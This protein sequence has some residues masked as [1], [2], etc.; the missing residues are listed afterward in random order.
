MSRQFM[1]S[2]R[3]FAAV[4]LAMVATISPVAAQGGAVAAQRGARP[5][6]A[7]QPPR[8]AKAAARVDLTGTWVAFV[9]E[10]W[11]FRMVTPPKGDYT[12]MPLNAEGK[13]VADLWDWQ[14]DQKAGAAAA[15]KAFG[16]PALMRIPTRVRV[17]WLSDDAL[18]VETDAGT[19]TR[20]FWF[21][22]PAAAPAKVVRALQG[23]SIAEWE[24]TALPASGLGILQIPQAP[25]SYAMKV[26]TTN[27]LA[28]YLRS[29]GVPYSE[30]A[31]LTEYYDTLTHT[32]GQEWLVI[33]TVVEDPQYLLQPFVTTTHFKRELNDAKWRPTP[34][35]I[36]PPTVESRPAF[37][38]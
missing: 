15:C 1:I 4:A 11:R 13:R 19:Q 16:A 25:A 22:T 33:T 30:N 10:D 26:V 32:N 24:R 31:V 6:A 5:P 14:K 21:G 29:N 36:V 18:K 9:T 3:L 28:G 35:E 38:S 2:T 17:S 12:S 7:P 27:L 8:T 20:T 37:P 23:T 34:C